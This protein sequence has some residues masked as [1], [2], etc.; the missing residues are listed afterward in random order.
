MA[1][2]VGLPDGSAKTNPMA[3]AAAASDG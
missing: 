3:K 2:S 1:H